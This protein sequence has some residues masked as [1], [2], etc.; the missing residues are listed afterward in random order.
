[1][2]IQRMT[3]IL[4]RVIFYTLLILLMVIVIYT[5]STDKWM[6]ALISGV[7]FILVLYKGPICLKILEYSLVV[8]D[9]KVVFFITEPTVRN[10]FDF[11]TRGQTIVELP[12]YGLLD[13][14]YKLE[15]FS[16][17]NGELRSC[18]LS[19]H[20]SYLPEP[21]ALQHAYD[22]FVRFQEKMAWEVKRVLL[23]SADSL[24]CGPVF[25]EGG[26]AVQDYLEPIVAVLNQGRESVGMK[27]DKADC[28]FT[29]C[30]T[31][32]RFVAAEQEV[33]EKLTGAGFEI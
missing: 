20:L 6:W 13:H 7:F 19:L 3:W 17:D 24:A 15:I 33:L 11:V 18:R 5:L 28:S 23:K 21:A 16:P 10:R 22:C 27:I 4:G 30:S 8:Q 9:G 29:S 2:W 32:V 1:M 25:P 12:H 26:K 14:A 31:A